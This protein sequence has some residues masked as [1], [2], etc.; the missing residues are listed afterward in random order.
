MNE[1][2]TSI[3]VVDDDPDICANVRDILSDF[4]Y[5]VETAT[6]G[7]G[8]LALIDKKRFDVALLDLKMPGM[9]GLELYREIKRRSSGTV[10][11][12]ISAFAS[13]STA[14]AALEAGAWRVLSK[15]VDLGE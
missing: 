11:V 5:D 12:I 13:T 4:G 3:L 9:N 6:S 2:R 10:A 15:P 8:S 1:K 14:Q 7:R